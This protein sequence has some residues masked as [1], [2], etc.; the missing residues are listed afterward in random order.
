M[1]TLSVEMQW[2]DGLRFEATNGWGHRLVTDAP[3]AS[4]GTEEGFKPTELLLYGVAACTGVDIVRILEKRRQTL[5]S[6]SIHVVGE[7]NDDYPK[8]FHTVRV[9]YVAT[10]KNLDEAALSR[11]IEMS[12]SKYC[13]VSQTLQ[14]PAEVETSYEIVEAPA[15]A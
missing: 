6:L 9:H 2:M 3:A 11:A 5:D 10:G 15:D 7:Q 8:P 13:V 4:G 1:S 14:E 12:E